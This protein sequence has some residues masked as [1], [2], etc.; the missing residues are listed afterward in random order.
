MEGDVDIAAVAAL[1]GH[2]TRALYLSLLL[3]HPTLSAGELARASRVSPAVASQH[4]RQL[5]LG[6]LVIGERQGRRRW[7]RLASSDV[8]RAVETL[9]RIAPTKPV[10]SLRQSEE[11][12]ALRR[13]RLCYD[14][15]AGRLGVGMTVALIQQGCLAEEDGVWHLTPAGRHWLQAGGIDP[16]N[17]RAGR[18]P[19]VRPCRDW[20]ERVPHLAGAVGQA[21]CNRLLDL[22]WL[23][24]QP[25]R[26]SVKV[27]PGA[28]VP[29]VWRPVLNQ[30][31]G[32]ISGS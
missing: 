15:L 11:A 29:D 28:A 14:H 10:R 6:G 4:L 26:R 8:A 17:L 32:M 18:R 22:G 13:A 20:S 24:R 9:A 27:V 19:L 5:E 3:A 12:A 1:I 2:R 21:L 25:G 7:Y 30:A 23:V 31:R 16:A